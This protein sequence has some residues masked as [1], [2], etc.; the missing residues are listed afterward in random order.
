MEQILAG[1][2]V[3]RELG[4]KVSGI[5]KNEIDSYIQGHP[6]RFDKRQIFNIEQVSFSPVKD[7]EAVA[8][9]TKD[10]KTI[11]QVEGKLNELGIKYSRGPGALDSATMPDQMLKALQARKSDDV[12]FVRARNNASVFKVASVDDKPLTGDQAQ[13]LAKRELAS[14]LAAKAAGD[15]SKASIAEAKFEGDYNRIMTTAP[16]APA[17]GEAVT[18]PAPAPEA[19]NPEKPGE[20]QQKN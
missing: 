20:E 8:A 9:S 10:F 12:F 6:D 11:D 19:P 18:A 5:S 3:Q 4:A 2:Y 14:E 13:Q 7:M 15:T 1:N 16:A 17:A